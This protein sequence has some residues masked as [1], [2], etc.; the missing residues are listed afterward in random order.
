MPLGWH[1]EF[2]LG[3]ELNDVAKDNNVGY[4]FS[5]SS[6]KGFEVNE[7]VILLSLEGEGDFNTLNLDYFS[8]SGKAE[9]FKRY[10]NLIGFILEY[11]LRL[12]I[13]LFGISLSP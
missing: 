10:T 5:L 13:T 12:Q 7:E 1:H 8:L 2:K 4:H 3:F 6:T 11:L 9:Y